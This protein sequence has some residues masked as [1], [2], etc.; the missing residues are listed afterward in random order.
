MAVSAD[1]IRTELR[2]LY[3]RADLNPTTRVSTARTAAVTRPNPNFA[4]SVLEIG[5]LG[6]ANSDSLLVS[7]NKRFSRG[8]QY[9]VAY[10]LSKPSATPSPGNIETITTQIW[11]RS[12]PGRGRG[13]DGP[14]SSA[15]PVAERLG[16]GA[17]DPWPDRQRA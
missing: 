6:W 9:R 1:Y 12:E 14:G 5:N 15:R 16:R 7:L 4:G 11:R 8:Y 13:A 10:T 3:M 17:E 2:D